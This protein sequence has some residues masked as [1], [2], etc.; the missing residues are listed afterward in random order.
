ME[1]QV[2]VTEISIYRYLLGFLFFL[3][4]VLVSF[5]FAFFI[6][7]SFSRIKFFFKSALL[8]YLICF[9]LVVL[10]SI[11]SALVWNLEG[12]ISEKYFIEITNPKSKFNEI[13][14]IIILFVLMFVA[15]FVPLKL[16]KQHVKGH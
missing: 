15:V 14:E 2:I 16:R 9:L 5:M 10:Y 1:N 3:L 6:G 4:P 12:K 13:K 7:K 11:V 8:S